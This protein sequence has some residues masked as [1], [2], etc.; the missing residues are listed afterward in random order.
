MK[1]QKGMIMQEEHAQ[2]LRLFYSGQPVNIQL[3]EQQAIVFGFDLESLIQQLLVVAE[4]CGWAVPTANRYEVLNQLLSRRKMELR[5][6]HKLPSG[7]S[8]LPN[9]EE[10][11]IEHFT[12][13]QLP[14]SLGDILNLRVLRC[15]LGFNCNRISP[16]IGKLEKLEELY[17]DD[18]ALE[19]LPEEIGQL[20][21]LRVLSLRN[22]RLL[23]L[24]ESLGRL[25]NLR[26]LYLA[27]NQLQKE[28]LPTVL[29]NKQKSN[30][31]VV[32]ALRRVFRW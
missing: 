6:L 20:Q 26:K 5:Y 14:A 22:N 3:A 10:L 28:L 18:N 16:N 13:N 1:A 15:S 12:L 24:P 21:N 8:L 7:L 32:N 4:E 19:E 25:P 27:S 23:T 29:R 30:P 9:L 31:T 11:E 17:L 2:I